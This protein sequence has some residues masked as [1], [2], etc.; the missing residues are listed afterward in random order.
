M[1]PEEEKNLLQQ[2]KSNPNCFGVVFDNYYK[3]I[4]NYIF[5][6]IA[7]YD[8]SRDI[9]AETFLKA[10]LNIQSFSWKNIS[11]SS[12]LYRIATNEIN[13]Y[14]RKQKYMVSQLKG[15]SNFNFL[16]NNEEYLTE[17]QLFEKELEL[18]SEFLKVQQALRKLNIKYQEVLSLRY[19]EKKSINE[20]ADI[21]GKKEGTVKSLLSRG[22]EKLRTLLMPG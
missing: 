5:K 15:F 14:F 17:K 16:F 8:I 19:F 6:R 20:I 22:T 7:D 10:Y 9:A 2:I 13:Y 3:S 4:F 18:H 21:L 12:W 1:T 11:L